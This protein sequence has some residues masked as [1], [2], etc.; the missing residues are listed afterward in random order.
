[1]LQETGLIGSGPVDELPSEFEASAQP[2][3]AFV[4][5]VFREPEH[6]TPLLRGCLSPVL[7]ARLDWSTIEAQPASFVR[8]SLQQVHSDLLFSVRFDAREALRQ[9]P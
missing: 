8:S 3:D 5:G 2:N 1:L 7:A 6:I 4:K 9:R